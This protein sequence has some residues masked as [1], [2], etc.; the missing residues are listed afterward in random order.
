MDFGHFSISDIGRRRAY[1]EDFHGFRKMA[2]GVVFVV[3]D[4]MGGHAGG[5]VASRIATES[6][7]DFFERP[8]DD[9]GEAIDRALRFANARIYS[10]AQDDGDLKGM[11]T[12]VTV[13]VIDN[14]DCYI[15]H[16]GDSRIYLKSNGKLNRLT[17]DHSYVQTLVDK[18]VI[19]DRDARKHPKRNRIFEALGNKPR[20]NPT[21]CESPIHVKKGDC[22]LLCTDG[23][24]DMISDLAI[25][26]AIDVNSV[27]RS[28][29]RLIAAANAAGGKDNVTATLV[30]ITESPHTESVFVNYNPIG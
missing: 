27:D 9:I 1:N 23:L 11:G 17:K 15:G 28:C 13:L 29:K 22:F 24:N 16:V 21:I 5:A 20:T 8:I 3:C 30:R 7:L 19:T 4:G 6:V 18:G 2:N 12:T 25:E 26:R 10:A 14:D